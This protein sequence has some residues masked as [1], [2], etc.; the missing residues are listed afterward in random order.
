[1]EARHE[2]L[3]SMSCE[4]LLRE[5]AR[6]AASS[7]EL[8][9]EVATPEQATPQQEPQAARLVDQRERMDHIAELIKAKGCT[10]G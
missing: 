6:L 4:E 7:D 5:L 8:N 3:E 10:S 2:D 9:A 1:M